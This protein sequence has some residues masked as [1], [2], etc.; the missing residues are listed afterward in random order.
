MEYAVDQVYSDF[1]NAVNAFVANGEVLVETL[2]DVAADVLVYLTET[3]SESI[4]WEEHGGADCYHIR[5]ILVED[6]EE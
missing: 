4:S 3:S 2:G 6:C 1:K 5:E